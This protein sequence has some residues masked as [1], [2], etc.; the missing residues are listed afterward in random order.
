MGNAA[1][2]CAIVTGSVAG[3]CGLVNLSW[4]ID[5]RFAG[6]SVRAVMLTTWLIGFPGWFVMLG[7]VVSQGRQSG[8]WL[9]RSEVAG[10]VA[11]GLLAWR[12]ASRMLLLLGLGI[13]L[14]FAIAGASA[15]QRAA[16]VWTVD[17]PYDWHNCH[18]PLST[19]HGSVHTC[20]SYERYL[21]VSHATDRIFLEFGIGGLVIE[22][23]VFT[24][25][26]GS[27]RSSRRRH[28]GALSTSPDT[29]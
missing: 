9:T 23:I 2:V 11:P 4:W 18:W 29:A 20:V 19:D 7:I 12:R 27:L 8:R 22:C 1:R 16:G 10:A 17:P 25:L 3:L 26:A 15:G 28:R 5:T 6:D 14:A 21:A 24:T 13:V